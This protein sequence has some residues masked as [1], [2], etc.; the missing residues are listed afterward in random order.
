MAKYSHLCEYIEIYVRL[1]NIVRHKMIDPIHISCR[2]LR[3]QM[4]NFP[5]EVNIIIS[6]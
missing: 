6:M 5:F 4:I 3:I 1:K 2:L